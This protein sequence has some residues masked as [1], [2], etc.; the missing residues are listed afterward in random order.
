MLFS[1]LS[2]HVSRLSK[3]ALMF[4][5]FAVFAVFTFTTLPAYSA[6]KTILVLG[7]SLSAEYG[8]ARGKGWVTL[9]E[10]GLQQKKIPATVINASISGDTT[11]GGKARLG[12]LL[13]KHHPDVVIIELGGNDAL[14]GLSLKASEDNFKAM[15][16]MVKAQ[17]SK[18]LL[19]GMRIPPNYGPDYSERF[20]SMYGKLAK[21]N[22]IA[23]VPFLLEGIAEKE[24]LFQADRI[25]PIAEAH[26]T[27]LNNVWPHLLP[28]LSK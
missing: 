4:V 14:R 13:E 11:S 7:D 15:I 6:S 3:Q 10:Q 9:L 1:R 23:L 28:L 19:A 26:P 20:F 8:L 16:D 12:T 18:V 27:I 24:S 25:H 21:A 17:H 5:M 2:G 22:K